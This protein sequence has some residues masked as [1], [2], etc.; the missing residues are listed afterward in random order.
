MRCHR[1][2]VPPN[3]G[4]KLAPGPPGQASA[5]PPLR[6][7][8]ASKALSKG[9]SCSAVPSLCRCRPAAPVQLMPVR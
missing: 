3:L 9:M 5:G 1:F 7:G 4:M 2:R 8:P 6:C